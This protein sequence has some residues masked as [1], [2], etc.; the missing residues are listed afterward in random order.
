MAVCQSFPWQS[1]ICMCFEG[2]FVCHLRSQGISMAQHTDL[3]C[4][5]LP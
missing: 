2:I 4:W 3:A 5:D 1:S